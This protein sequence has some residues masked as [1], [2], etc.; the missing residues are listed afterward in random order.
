MKVFVASVVLRTA[1]DECHDRRDLVA[2]VESTL[3]ATPACSV[4]PDGDR[5]GRTAQRDR[6][7]LVRLGNRARS[8]SITPTGP[9][10]AAV[11]AESA[12]KH[13]CSCCS[14]LPEIVV[15]F[16]AD[17]RRRRRAGGCRRGGRRRRRRGRGR[18]DRRRY[19]RRSS[20]CW[21]AR[22]PTPPLTRA[23]NAAVVMSRPPYTAK[24]LRLLNCTCVPPSTSA[25]RVRAERAPTLTRRRTCPPALRPTSP[26][27]PGVLVTLRGQHGPRLRRIRK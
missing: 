7:T 25:G 1:D 14:T 21:S 23:M 2:I 20:V 16:V 13:T 9:R 17:G 27:W 5:E 10:R 22:R 24:R 3:A 26:T 18:A 19:R 6:L 8:Q 15:C 11:P 4:E 12:P